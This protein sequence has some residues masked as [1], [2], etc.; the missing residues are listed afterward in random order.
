MGER[1]ERTGSN[2]D[3]ATYG[4]SDLR[5]V[6]LSLSPSVAVQNRDS[7]NNLL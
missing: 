6:V 4:L 7:R 2:P 5:K 3:S 1:M